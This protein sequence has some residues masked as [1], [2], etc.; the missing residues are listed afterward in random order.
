MNL[1]QK[2]AL[3][4]VGLL[5]IITVIGVHNITRI[6]ALGESIEVILREN[7]RS[8]V[9]CQQMKEALDRM[10]SGAVFVLLGA[11]EKGNEQIRQQEPLFESAL[12]TE[13]GNI[14][15]PGEGEKAASLET[16]YRQY[17]ASLGVMAD[18]TIGREARRMTYFDELLPLFQQIKRTADTIE[19]MNQKNMVE[20]DMRAKLQAASVRREMYLMLLASMLVAAGFLFLTGKWILQPIKRLIY[21]ANEIRKGNLDLVVPSGFRDEI[22]PALRGVQRNGGE[23]AGVPADRRGPAPAHPALH[24]A[25][26]RQP[27]RCD[28]GPHRRRGSRGGHGGRGGGVR[29]SAGRPGAGRSVP[30][31]G[32][33]DRGGPFEGA[34]RGR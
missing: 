22:E 13:L 27:P 4:F 6:T 31:D 14:T 33:S 28:R 32:R 26:L 20:M 16:L 8:V 3:G 29:P 19:R 17:R 2:L 9:A 7:Y 1:R 12:Q 15:L 21:S 10:D 25:G 11:E 5:M 30:V 24:A 34:C 18:P 23:P